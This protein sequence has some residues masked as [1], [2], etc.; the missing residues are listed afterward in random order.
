MV[1]E[2]KYERIIPQFGY[3]YCRMSVMWLSMQKLCILTTELASPGSNT[4]KMTP[5]TDRVC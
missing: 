1:K 3:K 5:N 4:Y 2:M